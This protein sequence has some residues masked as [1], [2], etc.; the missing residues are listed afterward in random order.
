MIEAQ[1]LVSIRCCIL[2]LSQSLTIMSVIEHPSLPMPEKQQRKKRRGKGSSDLFYFHTEVA[3]K[4]SLPCLISQAHFPALNQTNRN[5]E[6][7]QSS[8]FFGRCTLFPSWQSYTYC[9]QYTTRWIMAFL[10]PW[11]VLWA[12]ATYTE[13]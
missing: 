6:A 4:Y 7:I 13:Q 10:Q 9:L 12:L 11:V 3:I 2:L 5:L 8:L 1:A